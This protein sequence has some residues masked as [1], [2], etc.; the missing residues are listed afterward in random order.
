MVY[1]LSRPSMYRGRTL[2]SKALLSFRPTYH[3]TET[4][5]PKVVKV[6]HKPGLHK[7]RPTRKREKWRKQV[8]CNQPRHKHAYAARSGNTAVVLEFSNGKNRRG[9]FRRW[10]SSPSLH[11][12]IGHL[13][14]LES[15]QE[16]RYAQEGESLAKNEN[17]L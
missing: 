9:S 12:R 1:S 2:R 16:E 3:L 7:P 15:R 8:A 11:P 10:G 14:G 17:P 5:L 4:D 6:R 13:R